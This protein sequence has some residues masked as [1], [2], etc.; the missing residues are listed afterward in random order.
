MYFVP[1]L[2]GMIQGTW[3][4]LTEPS[5]FS[6]IRAFGREPVEVQKYDMYLK[7]LDRDESNKFLIYNIFNPVDNFLDSLVEMAVLWY[8]GRLAID[9]YSNLLNL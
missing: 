1:D 2:R 6:T 9:N 4:A 5:I 7:Q 3:K 8:G